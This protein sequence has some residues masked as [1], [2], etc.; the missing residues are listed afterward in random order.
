VDH[1]GPKSMMAMNERAPGMDHASASKAT[2][3]KHSLRF[4]K[5][6]G[7]G[8]ADMEGRTNLQRQYA[9]SSKK[10]IFNYR[11]A[12]NIYNLLHTNLTFEGISWPLRVVHF[13]Y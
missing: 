12:K 5:S 6:N 8:R 1:S 13:G 10:G 4:V 11:S 3:E 7:H 9:K 2:N